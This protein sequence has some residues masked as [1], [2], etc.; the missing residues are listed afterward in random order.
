[1]QSLKFTKSVYFG[2]NL[3]KK[4]YNKIKKK[5]IFWNLKRVDSD[6]SEQDLSDEANIIWNFPFSQ[7]LY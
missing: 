5:Y 3:K 6:R 4:N 7:K 2:S 1:M